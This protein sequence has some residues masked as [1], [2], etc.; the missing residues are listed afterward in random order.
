MAERLGNKFL[1]R[2]GHAWVEVGATGR[3][4]IEGVEGEGASLDSIEA[5]FGPL[6]EV[7]PE[8]DRARLEKTLRAYVAELDYDKHKFIECSEFDGIDRYPEEVEFFLSLW[9]ENK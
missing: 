8:L 2:D 6:T 9:E 1:D 3:F 7:E 5:L 4:L